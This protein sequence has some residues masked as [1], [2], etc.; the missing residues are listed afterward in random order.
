MNAYAMAKTAYATPNQAIR[1]NRDIEFDAIARATSGLRK[2]IDP[3]TGSFPKLVE[4]IHYNRKL[5]KIFSQDA[6]SDGNMLPEALRLQLLNLR[7]FTE[8]HSSKVLAGNANV[9]PLIEINTAIMRGLRRSGG[10][11]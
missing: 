1:T 6:A 10:A 8:S 5:W 2:A 9:D 4:A 3:D 7:K 11:K